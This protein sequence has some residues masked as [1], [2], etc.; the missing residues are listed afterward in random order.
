MN[1]N[2]ILTTPTLDHLEQAVLGGIICRPDL[3]AELDT[4]ETEDFSEHHHRV[5]FEGLRNLEASRTPIDVLTLEVEIEKAGRLDAIGGVGFLGQL[6]LSAPTIANASEYAK[7][8]QE[9]AT[10]RRVAMV[11]TD[12]RGIT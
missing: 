12:C 4:L 8:I 5:V 1:T 2:R 10:V 11:D 7:Q 9:R 3:L 6:C